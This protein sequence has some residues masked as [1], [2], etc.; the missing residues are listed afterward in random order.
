MR[1]QA[2]LVVTGGSGGLGT[3][4]ADEF[5]AAGWTVDAPGRGDLDVRD[6]GAVRRYFAG[7]EP[8][9]LVCAAGVARDAPLARLSGEDWDEVWSVNFHGARACAEA[10]IPGKVE[11]GGGHVVFVSSFSAVSP[12][13]GQAAYAAAKAALTGLASGLARE[14]GA[15][16]VRVNVVLPGFLDT[17]MTASVTAARREEV[18]AAH[19]LGRFNTCDRVAAF[20]RFL[21]EQLP[22]TSGQAF[23]L[24]SR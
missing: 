1:T 20:I 5:R 11:R 24:D 7:R 8:A 3:A 16:N 22:H 6:R 17:R 9:L 15:S 19:S 2:Y 14:H 10:A 18:L 12:P 13:V 23:Q 21:H 4:I